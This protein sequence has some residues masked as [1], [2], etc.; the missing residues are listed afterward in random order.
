MDV[1]AGFWQMFLGVF[2][3]FRITDLID[4]L[5]IAYLIYKL[6]QIARETQAAHLIKGIIFLLIIALLANLC[7]L[8][9]L[10]IIL[11][12]IFIWAPLAVIILFQPELRR[13]LERVGRTKVSRFHFFA[14][15]NAQNGLEQQW[16]RAIHRI[17]NACES[18][19][20]SK[21]GALIVFERRTRL[22]EV[23][24]TGVEIHGD[25]SEELIGNLFFKNSP[26][27]DG[28]VIVR[29]AKILSAS[30]FLP[31][32]SKE[33]AISRE[34]GSRHRAAIG[35]SEISDALVLV[36]SEETGQISIAEAGKI[37]RGLNRATLISYLK[38]GILPDKPDET[39]KSRFW[40]TRNNEKA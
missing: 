22:G 1:L 5:I 11:S 18:L 2:A 4:I 27:H 12:N 38:D 19:S 29:D 7:H 6:I 39:K 36:V 33:E 17:A 8:K 28:A 24:E 20:R 13:I 31:K 10:N 16:N 35:M 30:C 40:R 37:T 26:L 9:T 34:L 15:S 21:T 32:P 3:S 14:A 23:I 25:V